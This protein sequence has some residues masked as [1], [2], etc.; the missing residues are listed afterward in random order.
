[1]KI[2][3]NIRLRLQLQKIVFIILLLAAVSLLGWLSNKHSLQFDWTS[4]KR[5]TLSESSIDLL[6]AL[7]QAVQVTVYVQDNETVHAAIKEILQRYQ[8][9][10]EDFT[11]T[12][13]NPDVDFES[14]QSLIQQ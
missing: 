2:T 13:I 8:R 12:L 10:K 1:M 4:N 7:E 3:R 14:A 11:F 5:N 6:N 9:E